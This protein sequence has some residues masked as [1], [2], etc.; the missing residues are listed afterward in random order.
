MIKLLAAVLCVVAFIALPSRDASFGSGDNFAKDL[1]TYYSELANDFGVSS[2]KSLKPGPQLASLVTRNSA[3]MLLAARLEGGLIKKYNRMQ[4]LHS[5]TSH[6]ARL[7]FARKDGSL[8]GTLGKTW[9]N[10][11][12]YDGDQVELVF[13][14]T[15]G[16]GKAEVTFNA[17]RP[18]GRNQ[19][20]W[21]FVVDSG[22]KN[23]GKVFRRTLAN[24]RNAILGV[25]IDGKSLT[26]RI[27]YEVHLR[28]PGQGQIA[29]PARNDI[30]S[31]KGFADLHAHHMAEHAFAGQYVHGSP[32]GRIPN[33]TGTN[34]GQ[35]P[36]AHP[37]WRGKHTDRTRAGVDWP[38]HL[39][40]MH[41]MMHAD[42]LEQAVKG[43]LRLMVASVVNNMW[44]AH[45]VETF[46][47]SPVPIDDMDNIKLQIKA[48]HDF[49]RRHPWYR[50]ARDPWEARK[51][52]QEG[53]L[54]VIISVE[55]SHLLPAS[56]GDWV[57]Q[58]DE[59]YGMGVRCMEIAHETDSRFAGA[60]HHHGLLLSIMDSL[61]SMGQG[62]LKEA[63]NE[64]KISYPDF[65]SI[66]GVTTIF[67]GPL[68][69]PNLKLE[70]SPANTVGLL[71]EGKKLIHEMAKR[72][73]LLEVDHCSRKARFDIHQYLLDRSSPSEV[74]YYPYFYS[75]ARFDEL[76]PPRKWIEDNI[77][78]PPY[79]HAEGFDA[80]EDT[81]EYMPTAVEATK[82]LQVG[83][84]F[85]IRTGPNA[86]LPF[87]GSPVANRVHTSG[88]SLAQ[89]VAMG[90][91]LDLALALG[92]DMQGFV[93]QS[94]ARFKGNQK[95]AI[96][97]SGLPRQ[98]PDNPA[99]DKP[100]GGRSLGEYDVFG[101]RHIGLEPDVLKDLENLGLRIPQLK[102]S[103][104]SVLRMWER[105]Y[106]PNRALLTRD[107]Y[108]AMMGLR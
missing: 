8:V 48:I 71:P 44:L 59:L 30:G 84:V 43:G 94:G 42:Q 69:S 104:E 36:G 97:A 76:M 6:P 22:D 92:T 66:S 74:R 9:I 58:L 25:T 89:I 19:H 45:L 64:F 27:D 103:A 39:D 106:D 105:C 32:F 78:K 13:K 21:N 65:S 46:K 96:V 26:N 95:H 10:P 68:P 70:A 54:A 56:H 5:V 4:V 79:N 49:A 16:K 90:Q 62:D 57:D 55:I 52:I 28:R 37:P 7:E 72:K 91:S 98:T 88:R 29:P 102:D 34:H 73:M 83:G 99:T 15:G 107:T 20:L 63:L 12:P 53:K 77:G 87:K 82:L 24:V 85:G 75:H 35:M 14:K 50:V 80:K 2:A 60:A 1:W 100:V 108:K 101:L 17:F 18:N 31:V 41:Q 51:I 40:A 33:C 23:T 67:S 81:G 47:R 93:P 3:D 11:A 38:L 61:K 86:Q